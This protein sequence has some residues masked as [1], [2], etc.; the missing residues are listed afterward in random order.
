[1]CQVRHCG[2][3]RHRTHRRAADHPRA[4]SGIRPRPAPGDLRNGAE[5]LRGDFQE[6]ITDVGRLH[7]GEFRY[8]DNGRGFDAILAMGED[9]SPEDEDAAWAMLTSFVPVA[10]EP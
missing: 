2:L 5:F 6:C 3:R 9:V 8:L 4:G 10:I 1:M 7:G